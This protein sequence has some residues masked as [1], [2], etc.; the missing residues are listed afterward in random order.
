MVCYI[1]FSWSESL[2]RVIASSPHLLDNWAFEKRQKTALR[3]EEMLN[4]SNSS[5]KSNNMQLQI[6]YHFNQLKMVISY[7]STSWV[8]MREWGNKHVKS[9]TPLDFDRC[10][11]LLWFSLPF[12]WMVNKTTSIIKYY[13]W[14]I[15]LTLEAPILGTCDSAHISRLI[16]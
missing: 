6:F 3:K 12:N 1:K 10:Y 5:T 9:I 2:L 13:S 15:M 7:G 11:F 14:I 4:H 8:P 16:S